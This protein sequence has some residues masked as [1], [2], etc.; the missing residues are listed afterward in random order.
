LLWGIGNDQI[1]ENLL[2]YC[3]M[4][5]LWLPIPTGALL[6]LYIAVS[7]RQVTDC[8]TLTYM[9]LPTWNFR[10]TSICQYWVCFLFVPS[11]VC[12][13]HLAHQCHLLQKWIICSQ[14]FSNLHDHI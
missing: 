6:S 12:I 4:C 14:M 1:D 2:V 9:K 8:I 7:L 5:L 3:F 11:L 10:L 13:L